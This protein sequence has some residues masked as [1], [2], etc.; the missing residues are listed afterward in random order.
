MMITRGQRRRPLQPGLWKK[1]VS[2]FIGRLAISPLAYYEHP[3]K[4]DLSRAI[5]IFA[6]CMAVY[7]ER[8]GKLGRKIVPFCRYDDWSLS[9]WWQV[10]EFHQWWSQWA[11]FLCL[12]PKKL[13]AT[14]DVWFC[15]IFCVRLD[16]FAGADKA[17]E[18]KRKVLFSS[19][20]HGR[21]ALIRQ[22]ESRALN[23]NFV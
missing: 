10:S 1:K 18:N 14:N 11:W 19:L 3:K 15:S 17:R 21:I 9:I 20:S 4:R 13:L 8:E 22:G 12:F 23:G 5:M 16:F 7:A 6:S 2:V